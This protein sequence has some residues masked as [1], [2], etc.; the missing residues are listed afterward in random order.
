MLKTN[1]D[2]AEHRDA[3]VVRLLTSHQW[4]PGS[5]PSIDAMW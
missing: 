3:A 5:N 4:G 1:K 2:I